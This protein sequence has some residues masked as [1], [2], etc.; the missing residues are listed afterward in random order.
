MTETK[1]FSET[2]EF[3]GKQYLF[4]IMQTLIF[5]FSGSVNRKE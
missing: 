4:L 1:S 3:G 5:I 2:P